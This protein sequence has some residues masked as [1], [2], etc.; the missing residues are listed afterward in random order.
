[1]EK[2]EEIIYQINENM[3][4]IT[5]YEKELKKKEKKIYNKLKKKKKKNTI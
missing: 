2:I 5:T 1:M 3:K 4:K